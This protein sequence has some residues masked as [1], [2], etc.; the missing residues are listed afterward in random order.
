M[1]S[2]LIVDD[3]MPARSIIKN[4]CS[5]LPQLQVVGECGN[6]IEAKKVLQHQAVDILFLDIH[7]PVLDGMAFLRT[8]KQ[9]P[10]VI[11]TTA[12]KEHAVTAFDL[13]ACDY[14]VKP[15]SLER[16]MIAVE[17]AAEKLQKSEGLQKAAPAG[18]Y[19]FI[20]ADSII[21]KLLYSDV[22][23]AEA[24]GNYTR[25]VTKDNTITPNISFSSIEAMLPA[26][27]FIRVH[28]SFIINKMN[29]TR[30]EGNTVFI[31]KHE[32]P[33]SLSYKDAFLRMLKL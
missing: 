27:D 3:E 15:F 17:R 13:A 23:F 33:V 30:I 6:A 10:Q 26:D 22:L 19:F 16:F 24:R 12:Y 18:D 11:F 4:Y 5:H 31:S 7:M 8:L 28:R 1:F 20:K 2:C 21:H 32:V 25:I 14:L 9:L 29:I